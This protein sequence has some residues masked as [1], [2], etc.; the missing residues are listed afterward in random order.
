ML[1]VLRGHLYVENELDYLLTYRLNADVLDALKL[2][3]MRRLKL[4]KDLHLLSTETYAATKLL[5]DYRTRLAHNL[6]ASIGEAEVD[7][8]YALLERGGA[9]Q[10]SRMSKADDP[11][12]TLSRCIRTI[13]TL[14]AGERWSVEAE[15][16]VRV[17]LGP[18]VTHEIDK[19][20][21]A[22]KQREQYEEARRL[23]N[24]LDESP[25]A[26]AEMEAL[27]AEADRRVR[28]R[29]GRQRPSNDDEAAK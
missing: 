12:L 10:G 25:E 13:Y 16:R 7:A 14:Y 11:M 22:E 19:E 4:A 28:E 20:T 17:K 1:L 3:F 29:R 26:R 15:K 2:S 27:V 24:L 5:N 6:D 8:M 9:F 18:W 21:F 23:Q